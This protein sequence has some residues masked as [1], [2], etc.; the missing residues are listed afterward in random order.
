M[1]GKR[2]KGFGDR[3]G[4]HKVGHLRQRGEAHLL[5]NR[6]KTLAVERCANRAC[7]EGAVHCPCSA[8]ATIWCRLVHSIWLAAI[9]PEF[10]ATQ[11]HALAPR[12]LLICG[13]ESCTSRPGLRWSS[14]RNRRRSCWHWWRWRF[15][16]KPL[17]IGQGWSRRI[18]RFSRV[19]LIFIDMTSATP[20]P[21][22]CNLVGFQRPDLSRNRSVHVNGVAMHHRSAHGTGALY[23]SNENGIAGTMPQVEVASLLRKGNDRWEPGRNGHMK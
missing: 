12:C 4:A 1:D 20:S 2:T 17:R 21:C 16:C 18:D 15:V 23:R 9:V 11:K 19:Y 7:L 6:R 10:L 14:R 8:M 22:V 5:G 13:N 3:C